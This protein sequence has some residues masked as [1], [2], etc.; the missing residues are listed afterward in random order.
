MP[1]D[2]GLERQTLEGIA[3]VA[4]W[5]KGKAGDL[6]LVKP[7]FDIEVDVEGERGFVLPD[8]IRQARKSDGQEHAVVIETMGYTDDEYCERKAEQHKGMRTLGTLQTDPARWPNEVDKP[9]INHLYGI[10]LNLDAVKR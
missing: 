2:S 3:E 1:V 9:F 8:F 7:L 10:M 6:T 4:T 5:L